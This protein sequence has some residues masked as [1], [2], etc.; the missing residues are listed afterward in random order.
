[1]PITAAKKS[2]SVT[3]LGPGPQ[4]RAQRGS[5]RVCMIAY[6]FYETDNRVMRYAETL[7]R[8]GDHV[9]VLALQREVCRAKRFWMA[10]MFPGC[11]V[12]K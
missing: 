9:D 5:L 6:S 4:T 11:S 7:P 12:A 10:F 2:L 1:M 8:R 3:S